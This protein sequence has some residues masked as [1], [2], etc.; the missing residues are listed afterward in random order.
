MT[1][2]QT[3]ARGRRPLLTRGVDDGPARVLRIDPGDGAKGVL[4]D[5]FV[6]V[7]LSHPA[8][9]RTL[10][11]SSLRISDDCGAVPG[12]GEL[13]PGQ[14]VLIWRAERLLAPAVEHRIVVDGLHDP[15][16][17]PFAGCTT[18]FEPCWLTSGDLA[19]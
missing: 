14:T 18:R 3:P 11:A 9:A 16:G 12:R 8:D 1:P 5:T 4:R 10:S 19:I 13:D 17:R 7:R 15:S 2:G 6:V